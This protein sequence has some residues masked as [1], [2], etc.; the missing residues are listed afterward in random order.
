M[1]VGDPVCSVASVIEGGGCDSGRAM[2]M[3]VVY[4]SIQY[5]LTR[6]TVFQDTAL[7]S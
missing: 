6:D 5:E 4:S 1:A 2:V 7:D 3:W